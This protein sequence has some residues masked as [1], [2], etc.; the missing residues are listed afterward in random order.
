MENKINLG[1]TSVEGILQI[2]TRFNNYYFI[3]Y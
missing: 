2:Q 1:K 3:D